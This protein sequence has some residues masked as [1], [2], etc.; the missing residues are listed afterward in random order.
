M[1]LIATHDNAD[2]DAVASLLGASKLYAG[3]V[4]VIPHRL[5]RNVRDFLHLYWDAFAFITPEELPKP[6]SKQGGKPTIQRLTLVDT[7]HMPDLPGLG[8]ETELQVIDHHSPSAGLPPDAVTTIQP[9]GA[10][11]TLLVEEL[12]RQHIELTPNEATLLLLGIYEDSGS[13]L[14]ASTTNRDV[15]AAAWLL[16]HQASL[17]VLR[18]FLHYPLSDEQRSLYQRLTESLELHEFEGHT[19]LICQARVEEYVEEISTLAHRLRALY[20]SDA[21]FLL[22]AMDDHTQLVARSTT[23]AIDVGAMA[24]ALGGG[25]HAR[26]AAAVIRHT[27]LRRIH[28]QLMALLHLYV[29]PAATV[30]SIMS[31]GVH[32]LAPNETVTKAAEMMTR[33]GHEGFPVVEAGRI[34]GVL[35]RREIDKAMHHGLGGTPIRQVMRHGEYYVTPED[36]VETLQDL[37]TAQGLGQVPVVHADQIVGIVTRTDVINLW[38]ESAR[39]SRSDEIA[40]RLEAVVPSALLHLLQEAGRTAA[41]QDASL[42]IVG[43]FVRDL[44]HQPDMGQTPYPDI[45]L[46]VEGDAIALTRRLARAYGGEVRSHQRFGTAKWLIGHSVPEWEEPSSDSATQNHLPESLDFVTARMEFYEHPSA[47]PQVERSSIKQDL[48]RRD[49][50]I[51]TMAIDLTPDRYGELLDFYGGEADLRQGLVRVLHSLSFVED[52]TRM[53]RAVRLEQRLGFMLE[54]RTAELLH[55]ALDLLERVSGERIY[56]ELHLIFKEPEPER[57][58]R[59]LGELGI[60]GQINSA[61]LVDDWVATRMHTLRTGLHN[62]P[63]SGQVIQD[64]H[65]LGL[66][67]YRLSRKDVDAVVERLR[68][69]SDDA[70]VLRAAHT[71]KR[72]HMPHLEEPLAPSALFRRLNALPCAALLIG[73]LAAD[74]EV[75]R[76]QIAQYER[77]LR[78]MDTILDGHYLRRELGI[79]PG[80]IYRRILDDLLGARLDGHVVTA[81]E[82]CAWVD[83]WLREHPIQ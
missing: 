13:L 48:H 29:R 78:G 53:L 15:R 34:V 10:T 80:P 11:A 41:E 14:Y 20:E 26:A 40:T 17:E 49:F 75:V 37:M 36:S 1:H 42:F 51:N 59:R 38:S 83:R 73:W 65:Y 16:E 22:V 6:T 60:L 2:F 23:D 57:A 31:Y 27:D 66:L 45:D 33:Y 24:A 44:L 68:I 69:R 79:T 81:A 63:W 61:L 12:Q 21:L 58:L 56:H 43:G 46:V 74:D 82:E 47:L 8:P 30:G 39:P 76:A 64:V 5:N 54:V 71:L 50:T 67:L 3:A 62:T 7:Q 19:I 55:S 52:P 77:E 9:V 35:T 72:R 25:G 28:S 32:T 70:A 18:Q 4:A